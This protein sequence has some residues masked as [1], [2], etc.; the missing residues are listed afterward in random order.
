MTD[1]AF[2]ATADALTQRS[3]KLYRMVL[4]LSPNAP[5]ITSMAD[6]ATNAMIPVQVRIYTVPSTSAAFTNLNPVFTYDT[7]VYR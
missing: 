1:A 5:R 3:G 6:I 4:S 2:V 7:A